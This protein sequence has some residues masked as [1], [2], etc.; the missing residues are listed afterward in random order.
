MSQQIGSVVM[1]VVLSAGLLLALLHGT[2]Q[3]GASG[4]RGPRAAEAIAPALAAGAAPVDAATEAAERPGGRLLVL[5]VSDPTHATIVGHSVSFSY[6]VRG[7]ALDTP[8]LY[9]LDPAHGV[10]VL[11]VSDPT[12]PVESGVLSAELTTR[13]VVASR[14]QVYVAGYEYYADQVAVR[15]E[16]SGGY[17]RPAPAHAA[18]PAISRKGVSM[19]A[20]GDYVY[21]AAQTSGLRIV[22]VRDPAQLV[23]VGSYLAPDTVLDV[24]V[25]GRYAYLA[26]YTQGLRIVDVSD[27]TRPVE[28]GAYLAPGITTDVAVS[29]RYAYLADHFSGIHVV[30]VSDPTTPRGVK[31]LPPSSTNGLVVADGYAYLSD[32][33]CGLRVVDV[34]EPARA[35]EVAQYPGLGVTTAVAAAGQYVYLAVTRTDAPRACAAPPPPVGSAAASPAES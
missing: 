20:A 6:L 13:G 35:A 7:L 25:E 21:V 14:G 15:E 27:P 8:Y 2:S 10:R 5:D 23:A 28:V 19:A 26:T 29:G 12:R 16:L 11:D 18:L 24:A 17:D 32:S 33:A 4:S 22:D 34:R 3:P 9:L 30:D 1:A 31:V